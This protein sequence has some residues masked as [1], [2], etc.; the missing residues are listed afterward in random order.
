MK[1]ACKRLNRIFDALG[2][3]HNNRI[4]NHAEIRPEN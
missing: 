3:H 4:S 2:L 1:S